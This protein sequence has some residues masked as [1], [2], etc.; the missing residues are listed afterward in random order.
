MPSS[1][2][3]GGTAELFEVR[4]RGWLDGAPGYS[5]ALCALVDVRRPVSALSVPRMQGS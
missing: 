5:V 3:T 2:M 1:S 4:V